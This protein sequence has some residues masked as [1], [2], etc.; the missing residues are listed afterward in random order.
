MEIKLVIYNGRL[1][2]FFP[3][4][5][6]MVKK[7]RSVPGAYWNKVRRCWDYP[8][9][10]QTYKA[11]KDRFGVS[12]PEFEGNGRARVILDHRRYKTKPYDHQL[13]ALRFLLKQFGVDCNE[14]S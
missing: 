3:Y 9:S 8:L 4:D 5:L 12:L 2:L 11:L 10:V 6:D 1:S 14:H 13:E 7:A